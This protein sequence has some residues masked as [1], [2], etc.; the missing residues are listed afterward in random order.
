M[1]RESG[2][3]DEKDH[4]HGPHQRQ[5]QV[6][7]LGEAGAHGTQHRAP[8]VSP[9]P[10]V[11]AAHSFAASLLRHALQVDHFNQCA[12]SCAP[13]LTYCKFRH[14]LKSHGLVSRADLGKVA[15][16]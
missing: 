8:I 14:H 13:G 7:V 9:D 1:G 16:P 5:R 2:R 12:A 10:G 6:D 15:A 11:I 4:F 3:K